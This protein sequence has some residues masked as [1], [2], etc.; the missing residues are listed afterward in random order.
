MDRAWSANLLNGWLVL[1][2]VAEKD[3]K[4]FRFGVVSVHTEAIL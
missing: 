4:V 2:V 3:I 1:A